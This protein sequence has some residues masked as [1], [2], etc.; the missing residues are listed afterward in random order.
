MLKR[1]KSKYIL[2]IIFKF[3]K[4][5]KLKLKLFI[6]SKY[7][8]NL[9]GLSLYNFQKEYLHSLK[10]YNKDY[11]DYLCLFSAYSAKSDLNDKYNKYIKSLN[12]IPKDVIERDI[13]DL[14]VENSEINSQSKIDI[15]SPLFFSF[16]N[17]N[18]LSDKLSINIPLD[19]I[20]KNKLEDDYIKL[21]KELNDNSHKYKS[22]SISFDTKNDLDLLDKLNII[23]SNIK[24][25]CFK[26]KSIIHHDNDTMSIKLLNN[27][28][29]QRNLIL[30]NIDLNFTYYYFAESI[31]I[32]KFNNLKFLT[33]NNIS[34]TQDAKINIKDMDY[35]EFSECNNII[36]Y[37]TSNTSNIRIL[38][39]YNTK[40]NNEKKEIKFPFLTKLI[41]YEKKN[42]N[43]NFFDFNSLKNLKILDSFSELFM[44]LISIS[45]LKKIEIKGT[46]IFNK[47]I[48]SQLVTIN[49]IKK[50]KLVNINIEKELISDINGVNNN[51]IDLSIKIKKKIKDCNFEKLTKIFPNLKTFNFKY[52]IFENKKAILNN[53]IMIKENNDCKINDLK[54]S[55]FHS[56]FGK[57]TFYINFYSTLKILSLEGFDINENIFPIF[58]SKCNIMF[59]SLKKLN[60][61]GNNISIDI[62]DNIINNIKN[63][64]VLKYL[65]INETSLYITKEKYFE[66]IK[67]LLLSNLIEIEIQIIK[68]RT[69]FPPGFYSKKDL[70]T[71]FG[72]FNEKN[73]YH[74]QIYHS[75]YDN[76]Y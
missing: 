32:S 8:Q 54:I 55:L 41:Y 12:N 1:I 45:P 3:V 73:R 25:L 68:Y 62:F 11:N 71:I 18:S 74:F 28:D 27:E 38:Y 69:C 35:L 76:N 31:S 60:L 50:A 75:I 21:F 34:F 70:K 7:F 64:P 16:I 61:R 6:H 66:N 57:L 47:N 10:N 52:I 72:I 36:L 58:K 43:T 13:S 4:D 14:I 65:R 24:Y 44:K 29:L 2:E 48:L 23:V 39:I 42:I 67:K 30:L 9:F 33:L 63:C 49:S 20:I 5:K 22:I 17:N 53:N 59:T 26:D 46:D 51:L 37:S 40:I 19:I 15:Y 56:E